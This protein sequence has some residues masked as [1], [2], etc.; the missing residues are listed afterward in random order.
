M[1]G[2]VGYIGSYNAVS[3]LI[4]G[5]KALEYRGYDS[6]GVAFIENNNIEIYK[7]CGKVNV[8]EE[9]IPKE[10]CSNIG[11][12]H[13]RWATHG[14]PSDKN[15]HPHKVGKITLVHNGI[16]DN[17][18]V[19]KNEI[20]KSGY[21]FNSDTDTEVVAAMLNT[22]YKEEKDMLKVML[23]CK[24]E[25]KGSY[26]L[27]VICEDE[28]NKIYGIRNE[29]PLIVGVA[30]DGLFIASD[31]P[32]ILKYTNK[33]Q[34]L[35]NNDIVV[36]NEKATIYNKDGIEIKKDILTF[37]GNYE[38]ATKGGYEHFMLKEINEQPSVIKK[39]IE[40]YID[41]DKLK[42]IP[43]LSKYEDIDIVACGSAYHAGLVGKYYLE[44]NSN[45]RVNVDI[46]SEYVYRPIRNSGKKL[47]IIIS[48]SGETADTLACLRSAKQEKL[49]ILSIVNVVGSS[50]AR[51]SDMVIY[52]NAGPE[53]A[54]A[55]TK[56]FCAQVFILYLLSLQYEKQI[57]TN[58]IKKIPDL[59]NEQ[60]KTSFTKLAETIYKHDH[61][62]FIGRSID[63]AMCMEGS[64]KLK[65]CSYLHSESYPAGELKHGTIS[66]ID[67]GTPVIALITESYTAPKTIG[68]IK[69]VKAR[70]A[71]VILI[72]TADLDEEGDYY[73]QRIVI[74]KNKA[75]DALTVLM[76]LQLIAYEV[77]KLRNCD[78][79][80]PKNLAKSV[81]V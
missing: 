81:T 5:L 31:V 49:P 21:V 34:I 76:P 80:K 67:E 55:T 13:T 74:P 62:F 4:E 72:V 38:S 54:V 24:K 51:E 43:D 48:Q 64:L 1:C 35:E 39:L 16:I 23:R 40:M 28:Q 57:L 58:E 77:A 79:D 50:I 33:Y 30:E 69:E 19:L 14:G 11:I 37:E 41:S 26:A 27:G 66:L 10:V 61:L 22:W 56:A 9:S 12:G 45:L 25:L 70:G 3:V 52:T 15:S 59:I 20:L 8:L 18:L 75:I 78:I 29:S 63:Y 44:R 65:E 7:K 6:S 73:D 46:A 32:A 47:V 53:I 17:Y 60:V 42:E 2:I 71:Y 68:S 36:L